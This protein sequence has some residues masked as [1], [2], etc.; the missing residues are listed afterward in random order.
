MTDARADAV[1]DSFQEIIGAAPAGVWAAPGRANLIGEHTDYNDGFVMPFA[2]EQR[3]TVAGAPRGERTWSVTSVNN[4]DTQSFGPDDLV[5]GMSGW[6]SYVA[7]VVWALE[8]DGHDVRGADLVLSSDVPLGAGLSSSAALECAT[9]TVL[10]DLSGLEIE[11]M[12]RARLARRAENEFVGAPTGLM[13]QAASTLCRAEHALFLDCRSFETRHVPLDLASAGLEILVLDTR[14]PHALVDSEYATRRASCEAA[15][16]ILG[17]SAL[18]DVDA[19]GLDDALGRLDDDVMRRRVRHVVTENARV[20][21]AVEVLGEGRIA[22]LA[23]LLDASHASMRDDFEITVPTVDLA[24]ETARA[25]GALGARMTG[26]GFGGCIIALVP[27]GTSD[28]VAEQIGRA[29]ADA[30][31]GAP[32]HFVGIPSPGARRLG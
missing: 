8:Q 1:A 5:P 13:D 3:I 2:L 31:F 12:A 27:A 28:A 9:L 29:F 32:A 18:R 6:Q 15:A 25:A 19:A 16:R 26:G 20:L 30:G 4:D 7:G 10:A 11:P 17:V 21:A 24:V 23:P 22:D 14:T